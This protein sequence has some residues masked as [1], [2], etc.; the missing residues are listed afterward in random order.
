MRRD[1]LRLTFPQAEGWQ[2]LSVAPNPKQELKLIVALKNRV[3]CSLLGLP[4]P[5][6]H[7]TEPPEVRYA[8]L[9]DH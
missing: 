8:L 6:M 2:K 4:R 5:L 7:P 9:G 3:L 1:I